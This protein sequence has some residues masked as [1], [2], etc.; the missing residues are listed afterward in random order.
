MGLSVEDRLDILQVFSRYNM[1][2]DAGDKETFVSLF[3]EDF[4]FDSPKHVMHTHDELRD[5]VQEA[6]DNHG[7]TMRHLM[8]NQIIEG[9]GNTATMKCYG[10]TY[11]VSDATIV[12]M[13][14]TTYLH[15]LAKIDGDWKL[16]ERQVLLDQDV[17][18]V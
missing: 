12:P 9:D 7:P 1:S 4:F 15:K 11:K 6:M 14:S 16:T 3:S 18:N 2:L 17:A 10:M 5:F 13:Y 8:Y